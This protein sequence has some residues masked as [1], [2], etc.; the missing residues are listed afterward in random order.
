VELVHPRRNI[1]A[2][3][4]RERMTYVAAQDLPLPADF[5]QLPG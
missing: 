1:R 3:F 2:S 5:S 4:S